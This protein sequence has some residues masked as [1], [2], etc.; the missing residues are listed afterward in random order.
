MKTERLRLLKGRV[1]KFFTRLQV[2]SSTLS[3][4]LWEARYAETDRDILKEFGTGPF[5]PVC[6]RA[7]ACGGPFR[8]TTASS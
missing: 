3:M 7:I 5:S 2:D 1:Y 8:D 6:L 4:L